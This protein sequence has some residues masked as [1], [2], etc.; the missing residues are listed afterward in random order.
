ML[1]KAQLLGDFVGGFEAY[2]PD[3]VRKAVRVGL[4]N[5]YAVIAIGLVY[6][7]CIS[8]RY[9]VA[10]EEQHDIL[11]LLL[12]LPGLFYHIDPFLTYALHIDQVIG[13]LLK[14]TQG[15]LLEMRYNPPGVYRAYAFDEAASKIFLGNNCFIATD[16]NEALAENGLSK[17][18]GYYLVMPKLDLCN[19]FE[20]I[21]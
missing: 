11:Y 19:F 21:V 9:P 16:D 8:G 17:W 2:A 10:L 20:N 13:F 6:P 5:V 3:I 14:D 4:Y 18:R 7:D 15:V 1:V 12:L